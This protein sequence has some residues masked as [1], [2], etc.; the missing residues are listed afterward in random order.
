MS[1]NLTQPIPTPK[2]AWDWNTLLSYPI[3]ENMEPMVALSYHPQII[4]RPQYAIQ[5]LSGALFEIYGRQGLQERLAAAAQLL[6]A[7]HR[8][9]VFDAWRSI[10]TQ[11]ALFNS[12]SRR[13]ATNHPDWSE[14]QITQQTLKTVAAVSRDPK[15]PSPHNTGGS[16]DLTIV[17]EHGVLLEMLSPYDDFDETARTNYFEIKA[18]LTER[19]ISARDHRRLLYNIMTT[20]GFTNYDEE[21]WH[22]DFGNQN[23]AWKSG[24]E[25]ANYGATQPVFPWTQILD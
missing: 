10:S 13:I 21:W 25:A 22:Y 24:H 20:V 12:L 2:T 7:G 1:V 23:W 5:G 15:R 4:T 19:E 11:M 14:D 18:D 3:I 9:V 6:P 8:F 16:I 17:D